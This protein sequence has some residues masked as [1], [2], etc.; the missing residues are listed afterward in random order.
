MA[1][2]DQT[3]VLKSGDLF[4]LSEPG[5]DVPLVPS[6]G[7]GL[8][9]HDC[10]FLNGYTLTIDG[11][12]PEL[13]SSSFEDGRITTLRFFN[14][15]L[16]LDGQT[17]PKHS[18]EI[19]WSREVSTEQLALLDTIELQSLTSEA[20]RFS[21][22]LSFQSQFED[23]F[24]LRGMVQTKRGRLHLPAWKDGALHFVYEGAD[25]I[26]RELMVT[27]SP[28]PSDV[29]R[30]GAHLSNRA[31]PQGTSSAS[32]LALR[33]RIFERGGSTSAV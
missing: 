1:S 2:R 33:L 4:F 16:R 19:C 18:I 5:G 23:L 6:H 22:A 9:Y 26:D 29:E 3:I 13:H 24:A 30:S 11:Q 32:N 21:L 15:E 14:P 27:F 10:R 20:I 12:K 8:F 7:L 17:L 25:Q 28:P 31:W